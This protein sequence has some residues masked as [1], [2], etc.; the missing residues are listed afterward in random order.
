MQRE[1]LGIAENIAGP[2]TMYLNGSGSLA[3]PIWESF[4]KDMSLCLLSHVSTTAQQC[5]ECNVWR[6]GVQ[7]CKKLEQQSKITKLFF[8][9]QY[10]SCHFLD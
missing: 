2:T 6:T 9:N 10:P 1:G 7:A 4:L 8:I 3:G 5:E